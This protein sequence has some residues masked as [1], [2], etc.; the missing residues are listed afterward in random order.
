MVGI[1]RARA[2]VHRPRWTALLVAVLLLSP[3]IVMGFDSPASALPTT[4]SVSPSPGVTASFSGVSCLSSTFC[5][6]V[7]STTNASNVS[8]TLIEERDGSTWTVVPSPNHGTGNNS[9]LGVSCALAAFCVSVGSYNTSTSQQP[10]IEMWSGS[11]WSVA[12]VPS[13]GV[14]LKSVSSA[15]AT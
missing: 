15:S 6:A 13:L 8:Q 2:S 12:P 11:T 7:G 4:W 1:R 9:L 5:M 14:L 10:L 3:A